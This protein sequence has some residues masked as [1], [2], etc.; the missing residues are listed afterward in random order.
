MAE[1]MNGYQLSR[2]WHDFAFENPERI[3]PNHGALYFFI[4]DHCNRLGWKEKIGLPSSMA[5]DA[6][7]VRSYNTYIKT[8]HDLIDF[9]FINLIEKSRNQHSANII[10]LSNFDK[11][12]DRALDRA[13]KPPYQNLTKQV[14]ST[15]QSTSEST[16]SII[17]QVNNKP[18][19]NMDIPSYEDQDELIKQAYTKQEFNLSFASQ[20]IAQF[21]SISKFKHSISYNAIFDFV[22]YLSDQ[23]RFEEL[24]KQFSAYKAIK[25]ETGFA[26]GLKKY[27][28]SKKINYEDGAWNEKD[29]ESEFNKIRAAESIQANSRDTK[30]FK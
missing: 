15:Y 5:M 2:Q 27:L 11:A 22:Q 4:I 3:K 7:G 18:E 30:S 10:A 26:H 13:E 8:L 1:K 17:K 25:D 20:K 21:F 14:Q 24:R 12:L 29:W 16:D 9:G 28:G 19:I 23:G 6:I